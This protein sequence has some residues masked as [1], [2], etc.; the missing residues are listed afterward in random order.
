MSTKVTLGAELKTLV[1]SPNARGTPPPAP[2]RCEMARAQAAI[3][4]EGNEVGVTPRQRLILSA[5]A[6]CA[7]A[8]PEA[9]CLL[10]DMEAGDLDIVGLIRLASA[11][12]ATGRRLMG[13]HFAK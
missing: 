2:Q 12:Q 13:R 10:Y 3:E 5:A 6:I 7:I 9:L 4:S 1:A 8:S 11:S